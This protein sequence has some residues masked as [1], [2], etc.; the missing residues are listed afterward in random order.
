MMLRSFSMPGIAAL[1]VLA[2]AAAPSCSEDDDKPPP[3]HQGTTTTP[4]GHGGSGDG[5]SGGAPT[6]TDELQ[7]GDETDVDCGG[8]LCPP[9]AAGLHCSSG[10]DC[11]DRV[12]DGGVCQPPACNDGVL[13]GD[14]T[15]VDCGGACN[16][17]CRAGQ[18]CEG[19]DDCTTGAC[20]GGICL[21]PAGMTVA[22]ISGGGSYCIDAYEVTYEAYTV[23]YNAN[24]SLALPGSCQGNLYTPSSA[25]PPAP[26]AVKLPV[27]YVD[28]CDAYA[29]CLYSGKHLCGHIGGGSNDPGA[30]ADPA[31][32][33]WFNACTAQGVNDYPYGDAYE[34]SLCN[35]GD[36][37]GAPVTQGVVNACQG[38]VPGLYHM[39]GNIAEWEDSCDAGAQCRVRGGSFAA[40]PAGLRCDAS[41]FRLRN[42]DTMG[43]VGFRCCL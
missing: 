43:D 26:A 8:P 41:E 9:C 5:G 12:C 30:Y 22:P 16:Q 24:P 29:Y 15:D 25:W 17:K 20:T 38:G 27:V 31:S 10:T 42:N 23:F 6:C 35:G 40:D 39:S 2:V 4:T 11:E 13:N 19:S 28:W 33:E 21:C 1:A 14:E 3:Y 37:A 32:S 34:A 36:P 18:K 7:N